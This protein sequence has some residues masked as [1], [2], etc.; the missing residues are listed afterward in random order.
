MRTID[1]ECDEL[2]DAFSATSGG[3]GGH[4]RPRQRGGIQKRYLHSLADLKAVGGAETP[5]NFG[6]F[7]QA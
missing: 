5:P 4:A 3:P 2:L 6:R 1:G 7:S